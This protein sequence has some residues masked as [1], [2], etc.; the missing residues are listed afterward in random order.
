M[1]MCVCVPSVA[2][3]CTRASV[4]QDMFLFL[5]SQ[6]FSHGNVMHEKESLNPL[7][8]PCMTVLRNSIRRKTFQ[9][10]N[11]E[12][13]L[14]FSRQRKSTQLYSFEDICATIYKR[15]RICSWSGCYLKKIER[16]RETGIKRNKYFSL[17][18]M[19]LISFMSCLLFV[20]QKCSEVEWSWNVALTSWP[21]TLI[22]EL[23]CGL[24]TIGWLLVRN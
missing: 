1:Y 16:K 21:L 22:G 10:K 19:T 9:I 20:G 4:C 3:S 23:G 18:W 2:V 5:T 11:L 7:I 14:L 17:I 6:N 8:T 12:S 13:I 24:N 15:K